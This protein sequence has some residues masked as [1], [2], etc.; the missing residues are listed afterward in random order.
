MH[1]IAFKMTCHIVFLYDPRRVIMKLLLTRK[2]LNGKTLKDVQVEYY[3]MDY[4]VVL[5]GCRTRT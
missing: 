2:V 4:K 3:E 5:V 1:N